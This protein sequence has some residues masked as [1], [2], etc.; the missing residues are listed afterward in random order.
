MNSPE[1]VVHEMP[2]YRVSQI[3]HF[4]EKE[5]VNLVNRRIDILMAHPLGPGMA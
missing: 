1:I 5:L 3:I 4:F 2:A